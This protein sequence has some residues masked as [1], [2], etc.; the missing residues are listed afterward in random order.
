MRN[1]DLDTLRQ[2]LDYLEKHG[3]KVRA[4]EALGITRA[5]FQHRIRAAARHG[6]M[7]TSP[8]LEGFELRS[9]S[10]QRG[11]D[12]KTEREWIKQAPEAGGELVIP[13]GH[14][15][16]GISALTNSAGQV[17]QQWTKTSLDAQATE[18]FR[19]AITSA[20]DSYRSHASLP[21][22][23]EGTTADLLSV[24]PIVDLH[25][26]LYAWGR[27]TGADYDLKIAAGLLKQ[28]VANLV[29]RSANSE[30]AIILDM[31]DYF[32][33]DN[34]S[35]RTSRSGH[36]LDVDTR[37]ARVLQVGVELV[38]ECIELALQKHDRVLYRKLPGNHDDESSLMLAIA[39]AAWFRDNPR[40][41]V[42]TDPSRFFMYQHGKVMIAATHGDMLRMENMA[43]FMATNW[44]KVWGD[45]EFRYAYTGH[46]HHDR[47]KGGGGVRSE[48][49]NT[50]A[51]KDSWAAGMGF[52]SSRSAVSITMHKELGEWDRFTVNVSPFRG[53][54]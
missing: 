2:A 19:K 50:L 30:Q 53:I 35:N 45:T 21:P 46:V 42:D 54:K 49:F 41:T 4:A 31:G 51:A 38:V 5:G 16:K 10:T 33:T 9:I 14:M 48:S 34:S 13:Q 25:L 12:G 40:V 3:S 17:I 20:F 6:L 37:Y 47:V 52:P 39:I 22:A 36:T 24:Y 23:P 15:V 28:S 43:T 1:A 29:S 26:G 7:G 44:P 32:H 11:E 8:V 27:E 18:E